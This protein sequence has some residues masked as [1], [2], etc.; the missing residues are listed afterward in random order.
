MSN[1]GK[2]IKKINPNAEFTYQAEDINQIQ[3]VKWNNTYT[4]S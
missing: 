2:A 3:L 1:I 4:S